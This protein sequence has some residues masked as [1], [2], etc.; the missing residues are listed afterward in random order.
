MSLS[1]TYVTVFLP[2]GDLTYIDRIELTLSLFLFA[3]YA[4]CGNHGVCNRINGSCACDSGFKG[5][6]C[7]DNSDDKV[8]VFPF[9]HYYFFY[10][11]GGKPFS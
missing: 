10:F 5:D 9:V 3:V 7:L 1:A 8:Y 11:G 6:A 2:L 4:E